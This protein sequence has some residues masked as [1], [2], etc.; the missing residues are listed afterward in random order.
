ML[1]NIREQ[2]GPDRSKLL[3]FHFPGC[4]S[5][6][7]G[8]RT[9]GTIDTGIAI[10]G[11]GRLSHFGFAMLYELSGKES[12]SNRPCQ[13]SPFEDSMIPPLM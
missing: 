1:S 2:T 13:S 6:A 10:G 5:E 12:R 4:S 8:T 3:L 9:I 11:A 7:H